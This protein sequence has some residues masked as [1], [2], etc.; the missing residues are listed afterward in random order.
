VRLKGLLGQKRVAAQLE[1]E[2]AENRLA[3]A[4]LFVGPMGT[5]RGTAAKALFQAIN[6]RERE[7]EYPCG[8]CASCRRFLAGN[9]EDFLEVVPA[10]DSVSAQIKVEQVREIIRTI[11][12]APFG[13][14]WRVV[15]IRRADNL[16]PAGSGALLKTLEE[17]PKGNILVLTVQDPAAILPT[18]VSRCRRVN[19]KPLD[20]GIIIEELIKRGQDP[21]EAGLRA[22]MSGGSLGKALSL[23][24]D[25]LFADLGRF[26]SHL[27]G[28]GDPLADWAYAEEMVNSYKGGGHIDRQ[29]LAA[30]L[31][32]WGQYFRDQA[33]IANGKPE[34]TVLPSEFLGGLDPFMA[35][36]GFELVRKAQQGIL[37]NAAPEL[38]LAVLL[39]KLRDK[40][41]RLTSAT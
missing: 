32:L 5:G 27:K 10:T 25:K 38:T 18:L 12:F 8:D 9:H 23:D 39:G 21:A 34:M 4:Y 26:A 28:N 30:L 37:A 29:G 22:A 17:P 20:Q 33:V 2:M 41:S 24:Q 19:F 15:L 7:A 35:V 1:A 16:N 36:R 13:K 6:C 14:G 31:D 11:S 3:H 40:S